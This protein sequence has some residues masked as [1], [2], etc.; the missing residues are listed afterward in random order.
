MYL[1][2]F[3]TSLFGFIYAP[4]IVFIIWVAISYGREYQEKKHCESYPHSCIVDK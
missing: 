3:L 2:E 4:L 1:R